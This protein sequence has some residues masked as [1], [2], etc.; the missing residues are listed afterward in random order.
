[1]NDQIART[2]D[3][4][5][6]IASLMP[7]YET[8]P[9]QIEMADA[10][11]RAIKHA[12]KLVVEAGTGIGK[13][14]SYLVPLANHVLE[15]ESLGIVST[16]TIS[17]QE[18][19]IHK[20]IPFLEKALD[21]DFKAVLV[22]GRN[23]YVCI[24][25][26]YRSDFKQKDLFADEYEMKA[27]A[28]LFAWAHKTQDG[29][30]YDLE[31]EPD[32]KIWDMVSS[33][34]ETCLG[35]NCDHHKK[36]FFMKA[37]EKINEARILV[38][39]HHLFFANL[40]LQKEQKGIFPE[41]AVLIFDEAHNIENIA[42]EHLG[43]SVTSS[44]IR[45]LLDLLFNARRQKG[46]LLSVGDE[47]SMEWVELARKKSE[48]FFKEIKEYF[49]Q[50][51]KSQ[52]SDTLRLK[53]A[54]FV[55]NHLAI[56]LKNLAESLALAKKN[57]EDKEEEVEITSFIKKINTL[58][59]SIEL[60][61]TQDI[62]NY[63]YWIE[64]SR[65]MNKISI[66]TA[67]IN[68]G[69][70]LKD[71]LFSEDAPIILTSATLSINNGS[72]KYFRDRVGLNEAKELKLGSPFDYKN[73]VQMYI[74]K[75][76]PNPDRLTEYSRQASERIKRYLELTNGGAFILFTSYSLMNSVYEDLEGYLNEKGFNVLRQGAGL[77]RNRMLSNFKSEAGSVLF[78]VDTF[79]QGI[80]VQGKALSNVIITKLPFS[81]PDHPVV[82][83]RIEEIKRRGGDAFQE[84][85][86]PEAIL[87]FKQGFG[88]L[89]RSKKDTGIIAIL[90]S[91]ILTKFYG[92]QFLNSI[93]RCD[94]IID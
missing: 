43:A 91:R 83:A 5:G 18:Q 61:L 67:P 15:N 39:N 81:V 31:D 55:E 41:H 42:T 80:D 49:E 38:I 75:N 24:R 19:I 54:N 21:K 71:E 78:G 22:K 86:L 35:K 36:C 73:Q 62:E 51:V 63:T 13:S 27:F 85:N 69:S 79:W 10:I 4:P 94:I 9:E 50:K 3:K 46:L 45:Y 17:L 60:I 33:D 77:T 25:R 2:F 20:D 37:R 28:K 32:P 65:N 59:D 82:E 90:D 8:R 64:C 74:A 16:N 57:A 72:F 52:A 58:R 93:P 53:D 89:I 70:I 84:Y 30:L 87:K 92:R 6:P 14:F 26:L 1:M 12:E 44:G 34:S 7:D 47:D 56:P 68:V 23:N 11:D 29:S 40:A 76:M 66:N 88:R 48:A